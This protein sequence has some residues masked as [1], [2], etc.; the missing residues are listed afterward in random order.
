MRKTY[1][2][3]LINV[4]K[5]YNQLVSHIIY[6]QNNK[7]KK[8]AK[9]DPKNVYKSSLNYN[10]KAIIMTK[11]ILKCIVK[12]KKKKEKCLLKNYLFVC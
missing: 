11:I 12:F 5:F 2:V 7:K 4:T 8:E 9:F 1:Q 10:N 3:N 6:Q